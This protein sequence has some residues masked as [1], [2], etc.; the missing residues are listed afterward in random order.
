A[1]GY[2]GVSNGTTSFVYNANQGT[3]YYVWVRSKCS[4]VDKSSWSAMYTFT[5]SQIPATLPFLETFDGTVNWTFVNGTQ[6]NKWMV[7]TNATGSTGKS[8]YISNNNS[9]NQYTLTSA[10]IVHAY[11]D[12]TF[13]ALPSGSYNF[14]MSIDWKG[15]GESSY[16]YFDV[17]LVPLTT[18]I[19]EGV[20]VSGGAS[21]FT[22]KASSGTGAPWITETYT[23]IPSSYA[24]GTYRLVFSWRNDASGGAQPPA[25]IDNIKVDP[26]LSC[27]SSPTLKAYTN[28]GPNSAQMNWTAPSPAAGLGYEYYISTSSSTPAAS[29]PASGFVA[30][31]AVSTTLGSLSPNTQ[32]YVWMRSVCNSISK[33]SWSQGY[34]FTNFITPSANDE[35][36]NAVTLVMNSSLTYTNTKPGNIYG[37]T[38]SGQA[39]SCGYTGATANDDVWYKF[40]ATATKHKI[41]LLNKVAIPSY[42]STDLFAEVRTSCTGSASVLCSDDD[43]F[44]VPGLSI[45]TTYYVRVYSYSSGTSNIQFDVAVG[46]PPPPPANDECSGAV[47]LSVNPSGSSSYATGT[48]QSATASSNVP[49]ACYGTPSDDV[50]YKFVA[51]GPNQVITL[52]TV[53]P[54]TI[55]QLQLLSGCS[56]GNSLFCSSYGSYGSGNTLTATGLTNGTTYYI[57]V[58]STGTAEVGTTFKIFVTQ[59]SNP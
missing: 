11:R 5:Q 23:S 16:D 12:I 22:Y 31:P 56:G 59:G 35:C 7:G 52:N 48:L 6:T 54:A 37:A 32:Y 28:L 19:T 9:A 45:G 1:L 18:T 58:Y 20:A 14:G 39:N 42:N 44:S 4:S 51:T 55:T 27:S 41:A 26:S 8:M 36:T 38:A 17:R 2:T 47:T 10:S 25:A 53:S 13:G 30:S 34:S 46:T 33:S 21:I 57:R 15:A 24:N 50:W 3:T 40:T 29:A 49:L 43:E